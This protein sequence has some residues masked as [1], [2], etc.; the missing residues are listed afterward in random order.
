MLLVAAET[1]EAVIRAEMLV[2]VR[3]LP[4]N[5]YIPCTSRV[6][7][8]APCS[9][10]CRSLTASPP[11][12]LRVDKIPTSDECCRC[13]CRAATT[14]TAVFHISESARSDTD[15]RFAH[16]LN[17]Q[18]NSNGCI[19]IPSHELGI[20]DGPRKESKRHGPSCGHIGFADSRNQVC[21]HSSN[22]VWK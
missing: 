13:H 10:Q 22:R 15:P 21:G 17:W 4:H 14:H 9:S 20:T 8:P 12:K 6:S 5:A 18:C 19:L 7:A 3:N 2:L 1:V 11:P 16:E